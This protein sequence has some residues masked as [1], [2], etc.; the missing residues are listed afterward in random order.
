[1]NHLTDEQFEEIMQGQAPPP[2][3][4]QC[5]QCLAILTE[6]QALANRLRSTFDSVQ[7]HADLA[8]RIRA[9]IKHA[10]EP[11]RPPD[12]A[13]PTGPI[14]SH[15]RLWSSL[16]AAAAA[17]IVLIPVITYL[18]GPSDAQMAQAKLVEIHQ[19]NIADHKEFYTD[20]D[21][22]KLADY[23]KDKLGFT[24]ALPSLGHGMSIRGCCVAH[25]RGR[26]IGSYVVD[27]QR[28]VISVIV[29]TDSPESLG[30][31]PMPRQPKHQ[32]PFWRSSFARCDMVTVRLGDYSYCAVG[33]V[34]H[35]MLTDLL[36]R[37]LP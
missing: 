36:A 23:F 34:S 22:Q 14:R 30:M 27:T 21:P 5:P 35:E 32:Q 11:V 3:L 4:T 26:I 2:H 10:K 13:A 25:F 18:I 7:P 31:N 1:M 19:H 29:V 17:V 8:A 33:E 24:L 20:A 6:K 9:T 16:A 15:W 12:P 28:G 37:L